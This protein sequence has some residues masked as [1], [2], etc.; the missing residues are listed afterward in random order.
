M[1]LDMS[2]RDQDE[3]ELSR[4]QRSVNLG[5]RYHLLLPAIWV[6]VVSFMLSGEHSLF[7]SQVENRAASPAHR[8]TAV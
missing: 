1:N 5:V 7:R 3:A 8:K 2:H 4:L 6:C